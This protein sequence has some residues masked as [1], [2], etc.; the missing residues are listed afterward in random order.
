MLIRPELK[1]EPYCGNCGYRLTGATESSKCPECGRP[2][3]E[4]LTRN[5]HAPM[6]GKRYRSKATLFGWPVIDIALGPANG[7]LRG[8]ARGIIAIGDIAIGGL[9]LGGMSCG[10]VA[11]GGMSIGLFALG[12]LAIGL[13]TALGGMAIGALAVGGGAIGILATGGGAAGV[14]A[15]GGSVAGLFTRGPQSFRMGRASA[16]GPDP[17]EAVSWFFAHH[18]S[19]RRPCYCLSSSWSD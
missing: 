18:R 3:V 9:A 1:N 7:E 14:Y 8:K 11:L 19:A 2:L 12:G 16:P 17:F 15:Q 13:L 5:T 4:V 10:I 6:M